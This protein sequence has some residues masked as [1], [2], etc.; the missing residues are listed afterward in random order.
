MASP[1]FLSCL[2]GSEHAGDKPFSLVSF[3][4]CLYGSELV[5]DA[6]LT[7]CDFLSCLY[8]SEQQHTDGIDGLC[9]SKLPV[10]Q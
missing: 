7:P 4:S 3:L 10:R 9:I 6:S 2:Y 5:V 8:G 1:P